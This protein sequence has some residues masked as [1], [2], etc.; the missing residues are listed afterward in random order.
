[1]GFLS[2]LF[3][4]AAAPAVSTTLDSIGNLAKDIRQAITN[5]IPAD[6]RAELYSKILDIQLELAK[7]QSNVIIAEA[8]GKS[9]LQRNWR[10]ILAMVCIAII[11]W[12]YLFVPIIGHG[13]RPAVMPKE[14][15]VLLTIS[16]SGYVA[17]RSVEKVVNN[18][19]GK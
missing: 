11:A 17:G 7:M 10:P 2:K 16:L 15:W 3:A 1:M 9:W 4:K 18:I 8:Q 19:G 13:L 6:K 14:L 5:D 12:N